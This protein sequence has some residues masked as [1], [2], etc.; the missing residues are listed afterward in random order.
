MS[1]DNLP[2]VILTFEEFKTILPAIDKKIK[3]FVVDISYILCT[4]NKNGMLDIAK[5]RLKDEWEDDT[6][7]DEF[8]KSH[9][10]PF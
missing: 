1:A 4:F 2:D 7:I 10:I 5:A 3:K 8:I 9:E 6:F